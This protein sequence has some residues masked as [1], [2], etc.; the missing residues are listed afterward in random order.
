ML[1]VRG[2]AKTSFVND[3]HERHNFQTLPAK[4]SENYFQQMIA[5]PLIHPDPRSR[6]GGSQ[7]S[8]SWSSAAHSSAIRTSANVCAMIRFIELVNWEDSNSTAETKALYVTSKNSAQ[9]HEPSALGRTRQRR[10]TRPERSV[11]ISTLSLGVILPA[12][13][14]VFNRGSCR[15]GWGDRGRWPGESCYRSWGHIS[16]SCWVRVRSS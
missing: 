16:N 6:T 3:S 4:G 12:I 5:V 9:N 1:K 2:G 14:N 10:C 8:Q 11:L 13:G 7:R 15:A